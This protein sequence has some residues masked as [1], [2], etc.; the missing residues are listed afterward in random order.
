MTVR[1]NDDMKS[2]V[3]HA[4]WYRSLS[5]YEKP[6]V[7]KAIGQILNT[8][9]PYFALWAAMIWIVKAQMSLWLLVPLVVVAAGLLVRIFIFQHD[10]GHG[11]FFASQ[12]AN[13]ILGY[14]CG[15]LTFTPFD[16]WK[17]EHAAHHAA[18]QDLE[19]RGIGDI[20]TMTVQEYQSAPFRTRL[21]YRLFRNPFV[22]FVIGPF[23]QF[24]VMHR[25]PH[26][27]AGKRERNSVWFTNFALL[28]LLVLAALTIGLPT[29][30]LIQIP[31]IVV[32]ATV[33]VWMFYVQHQYEEVY[34]AHH[35]D[36][37]PIRAALEGSSYYRLPK[38]FQWFS[39]NIG[40]H[41]IHH[42]RPRIPNYNLEKCYK[43]VPELQN[44]ITLTFGKSLKCIFC[45][46]WDENTRRM[47]SFWELPKYAKQT[48]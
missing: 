2:Q 47:I 29:F 25:I 27:R 14:F 10:C 4:P 9:V 41:H 28:G 44:A 15:V 40:F 31:V 20:M 34:W 6:D 5:Q 37:D 22:L 43:E 8:F 18:A 32:A 13:R 21:G 3:V 36:W 30:L 17:H 45:H 33:G 12:K 38:I 16:D 23:A 24:V 26:K 19:R 42:L 48:A 35:Q 46:L 7:R 11:S 39:G 1:S